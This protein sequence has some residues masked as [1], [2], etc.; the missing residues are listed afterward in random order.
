MGRN[1]HL[2]IKLL[3]D[4]GAISS[5]NVPIP[6]RTIGCS[7]LTPFLYFCSWT[8][9][10]VD[11]H[12]V[13]NTTDNPKQIQEGSAPEWYEPLAE[14]MVNGY[15]CKNIKAVEKVVWT[16]LGI[17]ILICNRIVIDKIL[18]KAAAT[19]DDNALDI[20]N[21]H[22][23][24]SFFIDT[25]AIRKYYNPKKDQYSMDL[26]SLNEESRGDAYNYDAIENAYYWYKTE[27][28]LNEVSDILSKMGVVKGENKK[29]LE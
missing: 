12:V 27:E 4:H 20:K 11:L 14:I 25:D 23:L 28:S 24:N 16:P 5:I 17:C 6:S 19:S 8:A 22:S 15:D 10:E 7:G 29:I 21:M 9:S 18:A 26:L 13:Q 3:L 1:N 2:I